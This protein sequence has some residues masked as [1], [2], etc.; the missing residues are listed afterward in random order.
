MKG[1]FT[2]PSDIIS[3][4]GK[5]VRELKKVEWIS[6][7]EVALYTFAVIFL[8]VLVGLFILGL[9]NIFVTIR[10]FLFTI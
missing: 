3:Y 9:D 1:I 4:L 8:T 10:T 7:K 6:A 5:V 2:L